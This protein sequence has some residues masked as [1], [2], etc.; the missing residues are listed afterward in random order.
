MKMKSKTKKLEYDI[1]DIASITRKFES[2]LLKYTEQIMSNPTIEKDINM[3]SRELE[4]T[5]QNIDFV[6]K[7][8]YYQTTEMA[9]TE[10]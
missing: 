9:S 4:D 7:Y 1:K 8:I 5:K 3:V 10:K 2:K 6:L